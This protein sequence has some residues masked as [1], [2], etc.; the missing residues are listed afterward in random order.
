M[1]EKFRGSTGFYFVASGFRFDDSMFEYLRTRLCD[2]SIHRDLSR[3]RIVI[4]MLMAFLLLFIHPI[5]SAMSR[6]STKSGY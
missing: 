5:S 6:K 1:G 4:G 2:H 3:L